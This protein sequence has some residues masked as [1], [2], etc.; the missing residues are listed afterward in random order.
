[1]GPPLGLGVSLELKLRATSQ[2]DTMLGWLISSPG[3][4]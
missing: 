4:A 3:P 1:M 2:G